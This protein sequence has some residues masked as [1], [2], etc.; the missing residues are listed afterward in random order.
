MKKIHKHNRK[1]QNSGYSHH[2][3]SRARS[4]LL[5]WQ[6]SSKSPH[7]DI[8]QNVKLLRER[9][10]DLYAGGGPLGR[11]AIDRLALNVVGSG[12]K[13]NVKIDADLLNMD[14]K[15]SREWAA[16][17]EAE[18]DY[19]A[20]SKNA[21]FTGEFNFYELQALAFRSILL[22]GECLA[23]LTDKRTNSLYDLSVML[24]EADRLKTPDFFVNGKIIDE[25]VEP[26]DYGSPVAYWITNRHPESEY[27]NQPVLKYERIAIHGENSGRRNILHLFNPERIN[28]HRGVPFLAP[29]IESLKQLGRYTDAELM[30][31]VVGGM[32][33][34]FFEHEPRDSDSLLGEDY[35]TEQGY[36][37]VPGLEGISLA[38]MN[39]AIMD[40]PEGVKPSS[41]APNRPNTS[42]QAFV[43]ALVRQI[44][45]CLGIPS[46]LLFLHFTASY[47]ASRGALL[48]A[49]KLFRYWRE[50]F[51]M[52]F[53][54]P[55]YEEFFTEAVIKGRV[56]APYYNDKI[57]RQYYM[58]ASW[59]GPSQGQLDPVKEVTAAVQR[60]QNG[61]STYQR[62]T[63][64]L[65]GEDFDLN[66][67]ALKR[68]KELLRQI[69]DKQDLDE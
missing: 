21:S 14:D 23:V 26:D 66:V 9:S 39:G 67:K 48:E 12:L 68:E 16:K 36:G 61:F 37:E 3:A 4:S 43:E 27:Y 47:S 31:A 25:G 53:C 19:W 55:V 29:V 46:E 45:G 17:L 32:Y 10:R 7:E 22:D 2:G 59:T 40:L 49:W 52:N 62:E 34:L 30:A 50:W 41:V 42:F 69:Q 44:G 56:Q 15:Y 24:I 6:S 63:G 18:F 64:E 8:S 35:A 1:I 54:Q 58:W 57:K 13:L 11:G 51:A 28:Q 33:A 38:Q 20:S 5:S 60:V 65:T